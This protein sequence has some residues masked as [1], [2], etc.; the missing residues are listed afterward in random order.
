MSLPPIT[1]SDLDPADPIDF[2]N[3]Q[4]PIRQGL[5]DRRVAP[6]QLQNFRL[7]DFAVLSSPI[8]SNDR[9]LIGRAAGGGSYTNMITDPRRLGFL[10]GV[11]M[12]F[13]STASGA[14]LHWKSIPDI[15]GRVL[16]IQGGTQ[17]Y[18]NSGLQGTWQQT[19]TTLSIQQI[20]NHNH[21]FAIGSVEGRSERQGKWGLATKSRAAA[22]PNPFGTDAVNNPGRGIVGA[23]QDPINSGEHNNYGSCLA[24]N[25]GDT[26]RPAAA[27]GVLCQKTG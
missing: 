3:D 23:Y 19:G 15:G 8:N 1:I 2:T 9:I 13:Y 18:A 27:V 24:H 5:S 12:W 4:I 21:F 16:A 6:S 14:P 17:A 7:Q 11:R 20:P 25:H 26:W 22:V 10:T